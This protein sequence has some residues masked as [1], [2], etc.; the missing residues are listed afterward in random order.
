[1]PSSQRPKTSPPAQQAETTLP[2]RDVA[3]EKWL[4][5]EVVGVYDAM[6]AD[7]TRGIP[8]DEVFATVRARHSDR[9]KKERRGP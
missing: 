9:I 4:N 7:P 2:G 3:T 8:A 5:E 1:M 6:K